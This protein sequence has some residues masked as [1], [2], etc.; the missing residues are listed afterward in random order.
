MTLDELVETLREEHKNL[1]A[2][3]T[4]L[5][6]ATT[7]LY[8]PGGSIDEVKR[9]LRHIHQRFLRA[10]LAVTNYEAGHKETEQ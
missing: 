2:Y 4:D 8:E 1:C 10:L 5:D 7:G 6:E 9:S 3:L